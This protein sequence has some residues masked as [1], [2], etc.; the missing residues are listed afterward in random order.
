MI[1]YEIVLQLLLKYHFTDWHV[2][3]VWPNKHRKYKEHA[4][5]E[6]IDPSFNF[7]VEQS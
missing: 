7:I 1:T 3:T 5:F 6:V 4:F 2:N